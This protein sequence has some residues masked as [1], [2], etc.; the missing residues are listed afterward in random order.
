[1]PSLSPISVK[2]C[3][4]LLLLGAVVWYGIHGVA[5]AGSPVVAVAEFDDASDD[6]SMLPLAKGLASM[7]V[8]DLARH[9]DVTVVERSRLSEILKEIELGQ[10][11]YMDPASAQQL[12][13]GLGASHILTGTFSVAADRLRVD[14][15]MIEVAT[16]KI[17]LAE[18]VVGTKSDVFALEQTLAELL[19]RSLHLA[20]PSPTTDRPTQ[21]DL[22]MLVDYGRAITLADEGRAEDAA[23]ALDALR[24]RAPDF[25]YGSD[26]LDRLFAHLQTTASSVE[27][28]RLYYVRTLHEAISSD[29]AA[30]FQQILRFWEGTLDNDYPYYDYLFTL[31]VYERFA[32][33]P[34]WLAH[35]VNYQ[36]MDIELSEL[37]EFSIANKAALANEPVRALQTFDRFLAKH[38]DSPLLI[39]FGMPFDQSEQ[40]LEQRTMNASDE[41]MNLTTTATLVAL[42]AHVPCKEAL[43]T[44]L[45][46]LLPLLSHPPVVYPGDDYYVTFYTGKPIP[47]F[48]PYFALAE[49]TRAI[50]T[51]GEKER[52]R[53]YATEHASAPTHNESTIGEL[54]SLAYE[55][56][57]FHRFYSPSGKPLPEQYDFS[58]CAARSEATVD[59]WMG[60]SLAIIATSTAFRYRHY[61]QVLKVLAHEGTQQVLMDP[62]S[63]AANIE[64][65]GAPIP[66]LLQYLGL[67]AA[68][69]QGDTALVQKYARALDLHG[70]EVDENMVYLH[71]EML[72]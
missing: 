27:K 6:P 47:L 31:R 19:H 30:A 72:R 12:G 41:M 52:F 20:T 35:R 50:G 40:V 22:S 26:D 44:Y 9:P 61:D 2:R 15:R 28:R 3:G 51:A 48:D 29:P 66:L 43:R 59:A 60:A 69:M 38:P 55:P 16:G 71:T 67:R 42:E 25:R 64:I 14:A 46:E 45:D 62:G 70:V 4:G 36:G 37:L 58:M 63:P 56:S 33:D 65:A 21:I 23:R 10:S 53:K 39:E 8:T 1:M 34:A 54:A 57:L 17:V 49:V 7:L 24:S 18:Q 13:Q 68:V 32:N 11:G 5:Y